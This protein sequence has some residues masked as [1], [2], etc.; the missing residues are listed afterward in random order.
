[1]TFI[2]SEVVFLKT[3]WHTAPPKRRKALRDLVANGRLEI[4]TG[5]WV[6]TDEATTHL[7][8]L[9]DQ[10]MEGKFLI[11][12]AYKCLIGTTN[13]KQKYS[14]LVLYT[15]E[16]MYGAPYTLLKILNVIQKN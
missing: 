1:M 7:Y 16:N 13:K 10:L 11:I 15:Y 14:V 12:F 4:T 2:W 9:V 3:W 8:A 5:G 6:M